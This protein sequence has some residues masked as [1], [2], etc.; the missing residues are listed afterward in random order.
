MKT[1]LQGNIKKVAGE[2]ARLGREEAGENDADRE[3]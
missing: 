1:R 3:E 2:E